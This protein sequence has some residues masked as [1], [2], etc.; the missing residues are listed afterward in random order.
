MTNLRSFEVTCIKSYLYDRMLEL[1]E[2]EN[3]TQ[4]EQ[5]LFDFLYD[6]YNKYKTSEKNL[7]IK[8]I[9]GVI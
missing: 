8:E 4:Y 1:E 9:N 6:E 5:F 7:T 3:K 2:Y